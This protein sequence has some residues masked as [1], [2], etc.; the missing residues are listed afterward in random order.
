MVNVTSIDAA[1]VRCARNPPVEDYAT[2][3]N[4]GLIGI[5]KGL[6]VA[7][8]GQQF[9]PAAS[10][11]SGLPFRY[12]VQPQ[13]SRIW[14]T[15]GPSMGG[16]PVTLYGFGFDR[17]DGAP[18]GGGLVA[19]PEAAAEGD[20]APLCL[21]GGKCYDEVRGHPFSRFPKLCFLPYST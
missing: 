12:Y 17:F 8:N 13:L 20:G 6:Q 3:G 10:G 7:L 21:F 16:S 19:T 15:G 1:G 5:D 14:P 18:A 11:T 4:Y 9:A 2:G